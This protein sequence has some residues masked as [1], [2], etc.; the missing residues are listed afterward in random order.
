MI[1]TALA[2]LAVGAT[3]L[4]AQA[5][6]TD[7]SSPPSAAPTGFLHVYYNTDYSGW[8][9]DWSGE[10]P[11]WGSCRNEVSSLHNNGYPGDLD[12]I[13]VYWGLNYTGARRGVYRG[14]GLTDLRFYTFDANTGPG[15]GES[16]NDNISSHKW[17]N[18]P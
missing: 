7:P 10:A 12:D 5:A 16:L 2:V 13:W 4:T 9:D 11:D 17:T 1:G 14:A 15:S 18:L 3:P 8:C 6:D